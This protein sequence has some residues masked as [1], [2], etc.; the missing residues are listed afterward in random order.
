MNGAGQALWDLL[1][2]RTFV[3]PTVLIAMYWF[4]AL[5]M[6]VALWLLARHFAKRF[7]ARFPDAAGR[8]QEGVRELH[9][10]VPL[11]Y[12]RRFWALLAVAILMAELAWRMTIE[13]MLAYFQMR[14][15][16][17]AAQPPG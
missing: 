5:V 10:S 16:L 1:S 17:L 12:R 7:A 15:A 13:V 14:D 11:R 4:G 2:F 9:G 8:V 3:S 6:P